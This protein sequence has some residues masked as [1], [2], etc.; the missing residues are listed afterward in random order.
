MS[1]SRDDL[2]KDIKQLCSEYDLQETEGLHEYMIETVM[3]KA[4]YLYTSKA[5]LKKIKKYVDFELN[6]TITKA[7]SKGDI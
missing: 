2:I 6:R 7:Y 3:S 5:N 4:F 1:E